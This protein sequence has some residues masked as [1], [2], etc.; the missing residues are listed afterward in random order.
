MGQIVP[1]KFQA[2]DSTGA[3]LSGGKLHTYEPGTTTNKTTYSDS[4]LTSANAN[5][6]VLDSRGEAAIFGSGSYKFVLKDSDDVTIWTVDDVAVAGGSALWDS[7]EDS[8]L[9]FEETADEDIGRVDI[10]GT[11]QFTFQDG[12]IEPTTNNDIDLGSATKEFKDAYFD[13]TITAD[14]IDV[15]GLAQLDD[16]EISEELEFATPAPASDHVHNGI[17][18]PLTAG[19]TL[20]FG[21]VCY[22]KSDGKLWKADADATTTMPGLFMALATISAD[23]A[24]DFLLYGFVRD[25]SWAWTVGAAIYVSATAGALTE[26]APTGAGD[27]VQK[28]GYATHAD[29]MFFNPDLHY[30]TAQQAVKIKTGTFTGDGATSQAITGVGFQVKYVKIWMRAAAEANHTIFER[31]DQSWG[32]YAVEHGVTATS[33]HYAWQDSIISLDA[34]GFTVDDRGSDKHPNKGSQTYDYLALG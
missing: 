23:A 17:I 4:D 28:V 30:E 26:T 19:E 25:D 21:E 13:G 27:Q 10:G 32:N 16:V 6:V 18:V 3:P 33:E 9:Q 22:L 12:K 8:G 34:D 20:A 24:G 7:D 31:V 5:P 2:F 15:D 1:A 14:D 11:E 29:R